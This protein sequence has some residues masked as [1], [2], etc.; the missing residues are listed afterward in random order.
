VQREDFPQWGF[1]NELKNVLLSLL[2][3]NGLSMTFVALCSDG[4]SADLMLLTIQISKVQ[5]RQVGSEVLARCSSNSQALQTIVTE[6]GISLGRAKL[7]S[8]RGVV[9]RH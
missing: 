1:P 3:S 6:F 5:N 9:Y 2:F 7:A 4:N 8:N